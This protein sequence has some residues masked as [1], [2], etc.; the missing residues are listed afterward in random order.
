VHARSCISF[1]GLCFFLASDGFYKFSGAGLE[2]IGAEK[3]NRW[4]LEEVDQANFHLVRGSIDPLNKMVWWSYKRA[5]DSSETIQE[6][7]LGFDWQLQRWVTGTEQ[8]AA[9][10]RLAT[11]GLT[12]DE[13]TGT[14]DSQTLTYDDRALLG[15]EPLFGAL[16]ENLKFSLFT[17]TNAAATIT[18]AIS[19]LGASMLV[20]WAETDSDAATATLELGVRDR[21]A[22]TTTWK[23]AASMTA[24]GRYPLRGRGKALQFRFNVPAAATWTYAHGVQ[25]AKGTEGGP[26]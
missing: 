2:P 10:T 8:T 6:V 24:S 18:T 26:K 17:G 16:D 1:D 11:V 23:T 3:I 5:I 9:L 25:Y 7:L 21:L 22:A 12:Y 15:S 20:A 4:F 14:Y 13:A 19:S